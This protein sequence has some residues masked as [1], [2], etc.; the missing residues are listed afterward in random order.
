MALG[1]QHSW[2]R[3]QLGWLCYWSR[4]ELVGRKHTV[5]HSSAAGGPA[6]W[7][8][9]SPSWL[10]EG[11]AGGELGIAA[12]LCPLLATEPVLS[13]VLVWDASPGEA[14]QHHVP[15]CYFTEQLLGE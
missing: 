4:G 12:S 1:L 9:G 15:L 6:G 8:C 7:V 14:G 5:P 13:C 10:A 11:R 3:Q 2:W